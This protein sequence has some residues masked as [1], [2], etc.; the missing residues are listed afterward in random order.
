[1]GFITQTDYTSLIR[2]EVKNIL[3]EDYSDTKLH[4]AE[5]MAISQVKNYLSGK[6]DVNAI[7]MATGA[8][9]NSH[10]IMIVIDCTLYHLY[11]STVPDKMPQTRANRYQDAIDWLKAEKSS[12]TASADLPQKTDEKGE[13]RQGIKISSKYKASNNRW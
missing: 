5:Q 6:Y 10:I 7:F 8:S 11:T 4:G 1:M 9:R 13:V 2:K 3:L 12:V